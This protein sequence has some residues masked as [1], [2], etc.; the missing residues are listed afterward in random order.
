MYRGGGGGFWWT[1]PNKSLCAHYASIMPQSCPNHV[2][3]SIHAVITHLMQ[4][5][6]A[7]DHS[8][9]CMWHYT[10]SIPQ[11]TSHETIVRFYTT[12]LQ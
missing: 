8:H 3:Q 12:A 1:T 6:D 7:I 9:L 4:S 11:Q 5:D 2:P 10:R